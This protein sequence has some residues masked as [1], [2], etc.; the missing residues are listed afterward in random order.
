MWGGAVRVQVAYSV[1]CGTTAQLLNYWGLLVGFQKGIPESYQLPGIR[2]GKTRRH[3]P[4]VL[5]DFWRKS[6]PSGPR[7]VWVWLPNG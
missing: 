4:K 3:S 5:A 7:E 6:Q 1:I 2:A